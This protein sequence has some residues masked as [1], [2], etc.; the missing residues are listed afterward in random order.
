MTLFSIF[1][2]RVSRNCIRPKWMAKAYHDWV[3]DEE[4]NVIFPFHY[5]VMF[6][7]HLNYLWCKYKGKVSWID[8]QV[9]AALDRLDR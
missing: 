6:V 5:V 4:I 2:Q 7:W 8:K 9:L 1:Y 3:R